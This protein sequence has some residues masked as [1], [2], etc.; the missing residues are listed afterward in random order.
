MTA[1]YA[2]TDYQSQGKTILY[3]LVDIA[4]SPTG[5][6]NLLNSTFHFHGVLDGQQSA[7]YVTSMRSYSRSVTVLNF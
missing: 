3:V 7:C 1:A 6:L 4:T 2:F 5:G